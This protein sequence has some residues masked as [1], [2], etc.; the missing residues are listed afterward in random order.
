MIRNQERR[1]R[2]RNNNFKI[3]RLIMIEKFEK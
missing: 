3:N 1:E 2:E